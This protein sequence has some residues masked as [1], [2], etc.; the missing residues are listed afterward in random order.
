[1]DETEESHTVP[2]WRLFCVEGKTS[3]IISRPQEVRHR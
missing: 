3:G 1:M 2:L